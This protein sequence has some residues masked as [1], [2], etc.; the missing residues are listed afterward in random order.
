MTRLLNSILLFVLC[1]LIFLIGIVVPPIHAVTRKSI[2]YDALEK[3]WE[4]GDSPH[5]LRSEADNH[6][7]QLNNA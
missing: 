6:F 4:A 7:D 3:A 5:E 2:D 1:A